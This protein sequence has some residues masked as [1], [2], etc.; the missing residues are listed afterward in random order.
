MTLGGQRSDRYGAHVVLSVSGF[1][2]AL[3]TDLTALGGRPGIGTY[4]GVVPAF[5]A[6]R[7]G[8]GALTAPL[9]PACARINANGFSLSKH[10]LSGG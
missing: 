10:A 2:A 8:M 3:F 4:L 1:G 9:Y 5:W 6:I 7:F